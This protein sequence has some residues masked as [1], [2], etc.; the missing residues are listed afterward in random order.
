MDTPAPPALGS[1]ISSC[2]ISGFSTDASGAAAN[3]FSSSSYFS[4]I[5][6][7]MRLTW[8]RSWPPQD[9]E[10]KRALSCS[11]CLSFL[12]QRSKEPTS[13]GDSWMMPRT[14]ALSMT[15]SS[16]RDL[17]S[18]SS[19]RQMRSMMSAQVRNC[20]SGGR[21]PTKPFST[22]KRSSA[23]Q[24]SRTAATRA[25]TSSAAL[26]SLWRRSRPMK[27]ANS[28]AGSCFITRATYS[29]TPPSSWKP[30]TNV[31]WRVARRSA[32]SFLASLRIALSSARSFS[33]TARHASSSSTPARQ[34]PVCWARRSP[35]IFFSQILHTTTS[36]PPGERPP[37]PEEERR[38]RGAPAACVLR[39]S[40]AAQRTKASIS[41]PSSSR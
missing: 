27:A 17:S 39:I 26:G 13:R 19:L 37:L 33:L 20:T 31:R 7:C 12:Q 34:R 16:S 29:S 23:Q 3:S 28:A 22:K 6:S 21:K 2:S 41:W 14:H 40:S 38:E 10:R 24:R 25:S 4:T 1:R 32:S 30:G 11:N 35:R 5:S 36:L 8:A 18:A 9:L 15:S